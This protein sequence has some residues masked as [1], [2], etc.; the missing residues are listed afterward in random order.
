MSFPVV[1]LVCGLSALA[2]FGVWFLR[3]YE[4]VVRLNTDV[5][6]SLRGTLPLRASIEQNVDV[7][8]DD[9]VQARVKL[10]QLQIPL[11]ETLQIPLDFT[12]QVPIDSDVT[13]DQPVHLSMIV[14]IQTVLTEKE[15]D[16]NQL[17][18][19]IGDVFIDDYMDIEDVVH[20]DSHVQT[21]LGITV[22]VRAAIPFKTRIHVKQALR[23]MN[24]VKV[25]LEQL[26]IPIHASIPVETSF[27]LKQTFRVRGMI[28]VPIKQ[29]V[30][31]P[32]RKT[33]TATLPEDFGVSIRLCDKVAAHLN[34]SLD[35][36]VAFDRAFPAQ[37]GAIHIDGQNVRIQPKQREVQ[38]AQA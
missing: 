17:E 4:V 33:I 18:V 24:S 27:Q 25:Q 20:I 35:A 23:V 7:S 5:P 30:S 8:I 11:D 1:T 34:A 29:C 31:V 16:L 3:R 38:D 36:E 14:P 26:K 19:P 2:L 13:I 21:A 15:I 10:G 22:P 37:L 28:E 32:V 9:E 6:V 12:L